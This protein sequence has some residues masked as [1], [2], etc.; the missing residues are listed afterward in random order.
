MKADVTQ[1]SGTAKRYEF[2]DFVLDADRRQLSKHGQALALTQ[3]ALEALLYLAER[4]GQL[5]GKVDL[6]KAIWP[7]TVVEENNLNQVISTLRRALGENPGE[8][9][10][11]LTVP[12]RGYQFTA[13]VRPVNGAESL[14]TNAA[15]RPTASVAVLPFAN[16]TGDVS[17]EYLSDGLADEL[18]HM[19]ARVPKLKVP[20]RTSSFAYKGRNTDIRQIA[21]D[22]GVST[23]LEGSVRSAGERIRVTAQLIDAANGFHIWS[24]SYDRRYGD[25]FELQDELTSAIVKALRLSLDAN[26]SVRQQNSPPTRDIEAYDLYLQGFRLVQGSATQREALLRGLELGRQAVARDPNFARGHLLIGI[27]HQI[28]IIADHYQLETIVEAERAAQRALELDPTLADGHW[29]MCVIASARGRWLDAAQSYQTGRT[30]LDSDSALS[31]GLTSAFFSSV[32]HLQRALDD[33]R[34]LYHRAP[35]MVMAPVIVAVQAMI[36]DDD[37]TAHRLVSNARE[38]GFPAS[39]VPMADVVAA[40][41]LRAR[42]FVEA[43]DASVAGLPPEMG[44]IDGA[45]VVRQAIEALARPASARSAEIQALIQLWNSLPDRARSQMLSKRFLL[46][47]TLL[48]DVDSAYRAINESLDLWA[49]RGSIGLMWGF[50]WMRELLPFRQDPRFQLFVKRLGLFDYWAK[51]EPPDGCE[52]KNG[53]LICH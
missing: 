46:W 48:G 13:P 26:D 17:K 38:L 2:G 20:S 1:E 37:S 31:F 30:M 23:I 49:K 52:L 18:I 4:P 36:V 45:M 7:N 15:I 21:S 40:L 16:L 10:Y 33:A 9:R 51:Y 24:E 6:L 22:L 42:H 32:G 27:A 35:A 12:G 14:T 41:A 39:A 28:L 3:K 50:I 44:A 53:Q 34:N 29:L 43:A 19:L 8:Q 5:I 25:L 11:I 47:F